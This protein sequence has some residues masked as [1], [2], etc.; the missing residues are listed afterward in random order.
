MHI[1]GKFLRGLGLVLGL[2]ALSFAAVFAVLQTQIGKD[3]LAKEIGRALGD[4]DFTIAVS[5]LK[6]FVPFHMTVERIDIGDRDGTYLT[7][8]DAGLDISPSALLTG[9]AH[10]RSLTIAEAEMARL[11]TAPSTTPFIDYLKVPRLPIPVALDRLAIGK[12]ALAPPV[13]GESVAATVEGG[14]ELAGGKAHVALDLHRI[15]N[16]AGNILLAMD[17]TG[18]TPVL[19]LKLDAAEPTGLLVDRLLVRTDRLPL[20]LSV[21]GTGP[22]ANWRGRVN[23]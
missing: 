19:S 9:K 16:S 15:D 4:P 22:L 21:N 6:G 23:A 14:A 11:S 5:G 10:I 12:L 1:A 18:D 13:L 2:L 3:W 8:R 7:L 20:T 17:L